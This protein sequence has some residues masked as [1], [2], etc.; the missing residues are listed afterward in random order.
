MDGPH[1]ARIDNRCNPLGDSVDGRG[2][3]SV[4]MAVSM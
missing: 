1:I 2:Y 4:W 3:L